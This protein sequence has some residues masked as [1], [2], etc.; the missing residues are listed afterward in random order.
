MDFDGV[1]RIAEVL[2][3]SNSHNPIWSIVANRTAVTLP[4][5]QEPPGLVS[6]AQPGDDAS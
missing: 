2:P 4:S 1:N 5:L 3:I 6:Q